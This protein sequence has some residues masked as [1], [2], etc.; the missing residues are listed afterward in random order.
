VPDV[1][2]V[3]LDP[4]YV[5]YDVQPGDLFVFGCQAGSYKLRY[6][7]G[8]FAERGAPVIQS[9]DDVTGDGINDLIYTVSSCGARGCQGEVD[10]IGWS[11]T[12]GTFNSLS[13]QKI[14]A[15]QPNV[16][17]ADT[18]GDG[19]AEIS[20]TSGVNPN[21]SAG[22]QRQTTTTY[23]W[24]G[25]QFS[26]SQVLKAPLTYRIHAV[27]DGDDAL[28][29]GDYAAAVT[30][31]QTAISDQELQSWGDPSEA[32]TLIAFARF[33]LMLTYVLSDDVGRAQSAYDQLQALYAPPTPQTGGDGQPLPTPS[34]LTQPGVDFAR[35]AD[36]FW[37]NFSVNRDAKRACDTVTTYARSAPAGLQALNSFGFANRQYQPGELCPVR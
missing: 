25:A 30:A 28:Q 4:A 22:P 11:V 3:A 24:D 9:A 7:A 35:M 6:D 29:A 36:L 10:V 26:A 12:L 8:H 17:V 18:D 21:P 5:T 14:V 27:Y 34:I 32:A 2:V 31:Y 19:Q 23:R 20:V 15:F 1:F 16:V 33:R 37:Q 13:A